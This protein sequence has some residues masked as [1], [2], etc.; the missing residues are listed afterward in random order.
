MQH[1]TRVDKQTTGI[2]TGDSQLV[3]LTNVTLCFALL[4]VADVLHKAQLFKLYIDDIVWSSY[5]HE[6]TNI[7]RDSLIRSFKDAD[8]ESTFATIHTGVTSNMHKMKFL[9][10]EHHIN[11]SFKG[12]CFTNNF[13]K[14]TAID[15]S[16]L[17]GQ[18]HHQ[19]TVY[20][21][22]VFGEVVRLRRPNESHECYHQVFNNCE[23]NVTH[24]TSI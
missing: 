12:E 4:P 20:K 18:S 7:I 1:G 11:N 2:V 24:Q 17:Q 16:F 8:L 13:V 3:S 22:I 19:P 10:V 23:T 9:D 15:R 6:T 21:V 5:G 14:P